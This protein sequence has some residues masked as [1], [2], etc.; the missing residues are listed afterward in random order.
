[1]EIF[2]RDR[3]LKASLEDD[4][5]CRKRF[6]KEMATKL[7]LRM[8]ALVAAESLAARA[9]SL[10]GATAVGL[11]MLGL[12]SVVSFSVSLQ[13]REIGIRMALGARRERV[14]RG[15]A[16]EGLGL[17]ALGIGIG[18]AGAV[19]TTRL[20]QSLL[21]GVEAADWVTLASVGTV[22]F[23]VSAVAVLIPAVRASRLDP[24]RTLRRE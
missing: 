2:I 19:A 9:L 3:K 5:K 21:F 18:L 6:G 15:V 17:A 24:A 20:L 23:V 1:M 22:L 14:V 7:R 12:Y 16:G 8:D 10:F 4:A 13:T 11:A